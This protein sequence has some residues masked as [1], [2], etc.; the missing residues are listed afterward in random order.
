MRI[1]LRTFSL[2]QYLP[3]SGRAPPIAAAAAIAGLALGYLFTNTEI[4]CTV[5]G[6]FLQKKHF[7]SNSVKFYVI[8]FLWFTPP[9]KRRPPDHPTPYLID[10]WGWCSPPRTRLFF[11]LSL[12]TSSICPPPPK[13][14]PRGD[15]SLCFS[16]PSSV[17]RGVCC[18]RVLRGANG[19]VATTRAQVSLFRGGEVGRFFVSHLFYQAPQCNI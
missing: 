15:P 2:M 1:L 11:S 18:R 9:I 12:W 7:I 17:F 19:G 13:T 3:P 16:Q 8:F 14:C 10:P 6:L 4:H 5:S